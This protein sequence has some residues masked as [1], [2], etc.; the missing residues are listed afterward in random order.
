MNGKWFEVFRAGAQTDSAGNTKVWTEQ[1]LDTIVAK[2]NGQK[3]HEAPIVVGHPESNSP[4]FGWTE[5]LKREGK[6]LLAKAKEVL[7]AFEE[8]LRQGTYKK[9]SI[10]LYPDMTLRHIGF[11]GGMPPAV[12]GLADI[13]FK[14]GDEAVTYEFSDWRMSTIGRIVMRIRDYLVEKEGVEKADGIIASWEVQDLLTPPEP[15]DQSCYNEPEEEGMKPEEV[16]AIV[17]EAVKGVAQQFS[18]QLKTFEEGNKTLLAEIETLKKGQA[19][20]L[21]AQDRARFESFCD[22]PEMRTRITPSERNATVDHMMTLRNAEPVEFDDGK[23]GKAKKNQLDLY[24]ERLRQLPET[25]R[26]G[27]FAGKERAGVRQ[28]GGQGASEFGDCVD[29]D[30]LQLHNDVLAYQ[31]KNTGAS[32]E[33]ALA[34]VM[35]TKK[36]G[37]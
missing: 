5:E 10:S 12:K 25:V 30:R 13:A 20:S 33:T 7:P 14:E 34:A 37:N 4:S 32:Y 22:S 28:V 18:E 16:K 3:D 2:Y 15:I 1:D 36:G 19:A 8:L 9:R 27:E 23:G 11:L 29:E 35:S 31:E 21:D 17:T 26:L 6:I 24:Q